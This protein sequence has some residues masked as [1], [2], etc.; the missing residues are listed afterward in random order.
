MIIDKK[1]DGAVALVTGGSR[2]IG[3]AVC[4]AL[5]ARGAKVLINYRS[6][7]DAALETAELCAKAGGSSSLVPFD[8]GDA[9]ATTAAIGEAVK[10]AGGLHILVNNA[11]IAVNGLLMRFKHEDWTRIMNVNLGG[12]FACTKA[13][14]RHLLRAKERGRVINV[15]SVVGE[16]GNGGQS[17]Y[18]A[19]KAGIIGFTKSLAKELSGRQITV[20]AVAPGFIATDMTD[21][22]LP[23]AQREELLK[24]IPLSR[25]GA[26]ADVA[27]AVAFLAGPEAGY[28][29]GQVLRVN[30]GLLM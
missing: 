20:N 10:E 30:G 21:A 2:G 4:E 7:E 11:G 26:A 18:A 14:N 23:E 1:L 28:I 24:G 8:V 12:V 17:A 5:A 13:A 16:M 27:N 6:R 19:T 22:E 15:S 3:R 9:E 29:T 25:I